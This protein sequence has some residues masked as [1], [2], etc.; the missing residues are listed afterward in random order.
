ML[1][2]IDTITKTILALFLIVFLF[3][4]Y[5]ASTNTAKIVCNTKFGFDCPQPFLHNSYFSLDRRTL[6]TADG[7]FY[8]YLTL[9]LFCVIAI[10]YYK[11]DM[12]F[13]NKSSET[14]TGMIIF[15]IVAVILSISLPSSLTVITTTGIL[16][17]Y[18]ENNQTIFGNITCPQEWLYGDFDNTYNKTES[19]AKFIFYSIVIT[20]SILYGLYLLIRCVCCIPLNTNSRDTQGSDEYF[21]K[22]AIDNCITY[23]YIPIMVAFDTSVV[24]AALTTINIVCDP[25]I[26]QITSIPCPHNSI[27]GSYLTEYNIVYYITGFLFLG[28]IMVCVIVPLLVISAIAKGYNLIRIIIIHETFYTIA[29]IIFNTLY[30]IIIFIRGMAIILINEII[31]NQLDKI[32]EHCPSVW[33]VGPYINAYTNMLGVGITI[34]IIKFVSIIIKIVGIY[35]IVSKKDG[36]D[37]INSDDEF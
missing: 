27:F 16:C 26:E 21:V 28:S 35:P 33:I 19:L 25:R 34:F 22:K 14:E 20:L 7:I 11:C 5:T 29:S 8:T 23:I 10:I 1:S 3:G 4:T 30:L 6:N 13:I 36:Y 2:A 18:L 9:T 15:I 12:S 32:G 24:L 31:C 37:T 17:D